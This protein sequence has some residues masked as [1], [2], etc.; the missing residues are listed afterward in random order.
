MQ[1]MRRNHPRFQGDHLAANLG[2]A[3]RID[4]L[5]QEKGVTAAQL[6]LAWLLSRGP[7]IVPIPGVKSRSMID[8][9]ARA[10]EL[11][12]TEVDCQALDAIAPHGGYGERF[13]SIDTHIGAESPEI[14]PP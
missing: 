9:N 13:Q 7:D 2:L 8:D 3:S 6:A 11:D 4:Q 14:A 5:A 12:L 1:D 10:A